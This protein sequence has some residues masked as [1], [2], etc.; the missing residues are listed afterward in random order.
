MISTVILLFR[1]SISS[2]GNATHLSDFN[3]TS[4]LRVLFEPGESKRKNISINIVNDTLVE[5]FEEFTMTIASVLP[6]II[7]TNGSITIGIID[8]DG[9]YVLLLI[10]R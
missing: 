1:L 6:N 7:I 9:N 2:K 4:G 8:D 5:G 3:V 10:K